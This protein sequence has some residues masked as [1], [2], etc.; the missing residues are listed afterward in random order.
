MSYNTTIRAKIGFCLD[1]E[2][3]R[4]LTAGRC[5]GCYWSHIRLKSAQKKSDRDS[6]NPPDFGA[7]KAA[8]KVSGSALGEWFLERRQE[9]TEKC[10]ECG[11]KTSKHSDAFFTFSIAHI[12]PKSRNSGFP[13]VSQH[14]SNWLELCHTCHTLYDRNWAT[15]SKMKCF[16][17]ARERFNQFQHLI[18]PEER[19]RIPKY[20]L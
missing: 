9:M 18:A 3:E 12:L 15:A 17:V 11:G 8:R 7:R 4:P 13:S 14:P 1:C 19:R 2:Q 5:Q 6:A 16:E 10:C 20:F